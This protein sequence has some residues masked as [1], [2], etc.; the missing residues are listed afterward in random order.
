M[1]PLGFL[2]SGDVTPGFVLYGDCSYTD[3]YYCVPDQFVPG[4]TRLSFVSQAPI[5][6]FLV[7]AA[8][9]FVV[10][11]GQARTVAT[12]AVARVGCAAVVGAIALAAGQ[13]AVR[14]LACLLGALAL[15][16]P[17]VA[18]RSRVLASGTRPG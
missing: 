1:L 14:V 15:V 2:W 16:G 17:L 8:L 13:G 3:N 12:R 11:A 6:V 7:A 5:R 18:V 9:A 4:S 10:C